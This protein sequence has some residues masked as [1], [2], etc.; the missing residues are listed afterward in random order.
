MRQ[1]L[2]KS[3]HLGNKNF[4]KVKRTPLKI[5]C[6]SDFDNIS[7]SII[8]ENG[9]EFDKS[10]DSNRQ[11]SLLNGANYNE[12][13]KLQINTLNNDIAEQKS[14]YENEIEKHEDTICSLIK[15]NN[16]LRE[17]IK[18]NLPFDKW[19][20]YSKKNNLLKLANDNINQREQGI[21][22]AIKNIE[23]EELVVITLLKT[24]HEDNKENTDEEDKENHRS[25]QIQDAAKMFLSPFKSFT[26]SSPH[27]DPIA[28]RN[29][30]SLKDIDKKLN[31]IEKAWNMKY[32]YSLGKEKQW[33]IIGSTV[34]S[35]EK[36]VKQRN[37]FMKRNNKDHDESEEDELYF[38]HNYYCKVANEN[39]ELKNQIS[40]L[41]CQV[42]Q[43]QK[44]MKKAKK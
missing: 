25:L 39:Q 34:T 28:E 10:K 1:F 20:S 6:I 22:R 35:P 37:S 36:K 11:D 18:N 21:Q 42:Y 13:L 27:K 15:E 29:E 24:L 16:E 4:D 5:L 31:S 23:K 19:N 41:E 14:L 43:L 32:N 40:I 17:K 26:P 2:S 44:K 8:T 12:E 38:W 30:K 7:T 9:D 3:L 33:S